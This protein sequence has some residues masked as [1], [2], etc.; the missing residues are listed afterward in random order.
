MVDSYDG[1]LEEP[2]T[3][4]VHENCVAKLVPAISLVARGLDYGKSCE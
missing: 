4:S 3:C 1:R 2:G